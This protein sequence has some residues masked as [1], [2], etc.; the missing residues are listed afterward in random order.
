MERYVSL[1]QQKP[2]VERRS[3]CKGADEPLDEEECIPQALVIICRVIM[4]SAL[5]IA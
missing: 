1:P 2:S 3:S 5:Q 4:M